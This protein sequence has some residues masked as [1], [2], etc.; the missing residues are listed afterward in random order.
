MEF[1]RSTGVDY[2]LV[3][4]DDFGSKFRRAKYFHEPYNSYIKGLKGDCPVSEF[5]FAD[6]P[7]GSIVYSDGFFKVI[8]LRL[9]R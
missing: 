1:S 8:D 4:T 3:R 9:L 6:P 7:A 5:V 2:M